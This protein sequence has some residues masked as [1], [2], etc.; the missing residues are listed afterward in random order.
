VE[1]AAVD[2]SSGTILSQLSTNGGWGNSNR[3]Q[4]D[5]SIDV[6]YTDSSTVQL[7]F[8]DGGVY[9]PDSDIP[10]QVPV[11]PGGASIGF[12]S[13]QGTTCDGGDCHYLAVDTANKKLFEVDQGSIVNNSFT[14]DGSVAIWDFLKIYPSSLRG[15]VCTSADAGGLP[16]APLLFTAE[17]VAAG[18]ITHAIRFILPNSRIQ[19]RQYVRPATHGTGSSN[20]S[21]WATSNGVPYG[22]RLRLKPSFDLSTLPSAGARVVGQALKTYG[23]ILADGGQIALTA[24]SDASSSTKWSSL[25]GPTDLRALQPVDFEMINAGTR[26]NF[27]SFDCVRNP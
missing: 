19:C 25:L 3:F 7:P 9:Q 1:N 18:V 17:E 15:D 27:S 24:K 11:P 2:A 10:T 16:I 8:T 12:E 20:C 5:F 22:A 23:M 14:S 6:Y 4:I 13:S 26:I 21:G